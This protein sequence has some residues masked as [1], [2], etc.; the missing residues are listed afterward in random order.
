MTLTRTV[1]AV[2]SLLLSAA[3]THA[4]EYAKDQRLMV[5]GGPTRRALRA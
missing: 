4:A 2:S 1:A 5:I 3:A